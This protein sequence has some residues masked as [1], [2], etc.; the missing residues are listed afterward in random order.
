MTRIIFLNRYFHPDHSATSQILSDLAFHLAA[1]GRDIHV[2]T[3]RQLYDDPSAQLP[4][5]ETVNGVTVHRVSTSRFGRN[6]LPGRAFDYLTFYAAVWRHVSAL[7]RPGDIVVA[8]TDPPLLSVVAQYA[9]RRRRARLVNWLQDLYPEVAAELG[10]PLMKGPLGSLLAHFRNRSLRKAGANVVICT[11][12][13]AR[14]AANEAKDAI[15]VIPNWCDDERIVPAPS[16][17]NPLRAAWGLTAKFVVGYSGNLGRAHEF[18][19]MLD[20]AERLRD[21]S[22]IVFVCIGGGLHFDA[23]SLAVRSRGLARQFQFRPYQ[24]QGALKY[25]LTLPDVHWISL[26]PQLEGLLFP[27]KLYGIAAAGR[28]VIA[29]ADTHGEIAGLLE[30]HRC[31]F[32]VAPGDA[33]GLA[34]LIATLSRAP[35]ECAALGSR[36]RAMLDAE[37]TRHQAL[38][39]WDRLF[40][41]L[42]VD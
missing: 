13:A 1:G 17:E 41:A 20:A 19:T 25:S 23:M 8:K 26:R 9:A 38:Q 10:V 42:A 27:S 15:H 7:A 14:A 37:F 21:N 12:M 24:E 32:A 6:S 4:P 22:D 3:S 11:A 5:H 39:R 31:G 40:A 28:P 18:D 2:V 36:A 34:D 33:G 35:E 29:I 16:R 30:R